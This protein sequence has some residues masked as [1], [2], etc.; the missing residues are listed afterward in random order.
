MMRIRDEAEE[1][2]F[3]HQLDRESGDVDG[4]DDHEGRR[5][6]GAAGDA[7]GSPG[8]GESSFAVGTADCSRFSS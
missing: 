5:D 8:G 2:A 4:P 1:V 7:V 3:L 6:V